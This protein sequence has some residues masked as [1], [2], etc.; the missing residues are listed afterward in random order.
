MLP[1][2]GEIPDVVIDH[3]RRCLEL[4]DDVWPDRGSSLIASWC[5]SVRA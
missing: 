1:S 4:A 3:V 5:A 2:P